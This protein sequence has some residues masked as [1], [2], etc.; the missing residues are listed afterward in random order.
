[1]DSPKLMLVP[2][3]HL[4]SPRSNRPNR[5]SPHLDSEVLGIGI[6]AVPRDLRSLAITLE[7]IQTYLPLHCGHPHY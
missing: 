7:P 1:M 5:A 3:E 6:I 2:L 4:K